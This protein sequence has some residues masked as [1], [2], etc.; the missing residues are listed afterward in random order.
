MLNVMDF[1]TFNDGSKGSEGSVESTLKDNDA[2]DFQCL[3]CELH[4]LEAQ[5]LGES[6]GAVC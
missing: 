5:S 1:I 4:L 2:E 3:L 6:A